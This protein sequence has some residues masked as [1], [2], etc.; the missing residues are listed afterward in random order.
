MLFVT[1]IIIFI[2]ITIFILGITYWKSNLYRNQ[3]FKV[4]FSS[5]SAIAIIFSVL[6]ITIQA[7][8]YIETINLNNTTSYNRLTET[9]FIGI[10]QMFLY[11]KDMQYFYDDLMGI[12]HID[13]NTQHRNYIKENQMSMLIFSRSIP[14]I[15]YIQSNNYDYEKTFQLV[16]RFN[17]VMH[18]FFQSKIFQKYWY[19]YEEK[20][21]GDPPRIYFKREF[22]IKSKHWADPSKEPEFKPTIKL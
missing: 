11:N 21:A 4:F 18:T 17:H 1:Y 8:S 7:F 22:N 6:A 12:K 2:I 13:E 20:L 16:S 15:Y 19:I 10:F 5:I 14:I 3:K 9:F